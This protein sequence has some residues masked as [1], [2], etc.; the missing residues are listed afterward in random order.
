MHLRKRERARKKES[1]AHVFGNSIEH[2][3][4]DITFHRF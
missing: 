1:I 2:S 3:N 4:D